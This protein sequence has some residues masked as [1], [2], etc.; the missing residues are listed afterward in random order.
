MRYHDLPTE[1]HITHNT[2][3]IGT[4]GEKEKKKNTTSFK[5]CN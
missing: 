1:T 5:A 2:V 4:I 3:E